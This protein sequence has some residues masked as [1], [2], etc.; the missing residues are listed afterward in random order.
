MRSC[1]LLPV[2]VV[3]W[4]QGCRAREGRCAPVGGTPVPS[5]QRKLAV[6]TK[7]Q[8]RRGASDGFARGC[9]ENQ[10]CGMHTVPTCLRAYTRYP[11]NPRMTC[12]ADHP[13]FPTG[14]VRTLRFSGTN[15]SAKVKLATPAAWRLAANPPLPHACSAPCPL[16]KP[17]PVSDPQTLL[18]APELQP[19]LPLHLPP[20][21]PLPPR[22]L[23]LTAPVNSLLGVSVE[24]YALRCHVC[25]VVLGW[26]PGCV[27]QECACTCW[28]FTRRCKYQAAGER[29]L[30]PAKGH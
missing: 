14:H 1:V 26:P 15:A 20:H 16:S 5:G 11:D 24:K 6:W 19:S 10:K 3:S 4:H 13:H 28:W 23:R 30:S 7:R 29:K 27:L 25:A 9:G 12:E 18:A 8:P 17:G 22:L 21:A 2:L